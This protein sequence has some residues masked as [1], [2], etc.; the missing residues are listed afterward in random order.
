M[1]RKIVEESRT[2][3]SLSLEMDASGR[4][5]P[6]MKL[7]FEQPQEWKTYAGMAQ[8]A[9]SYL[10][11]EKQEKPVLERDAWG[12]FVSPGKSNQKGG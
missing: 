3:T 7:Y 9:L 8:E 4:L 1:R 11:G 2:L 6:T 10:R 5:K 12:R